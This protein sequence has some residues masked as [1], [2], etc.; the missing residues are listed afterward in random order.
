[1][2]Q[3]VV[4][5]VLPP[6]HGFEPCPPPLVD[7]MLTLPS[8]ATHRYGSSRDDVSNWTAGARDIS[9]FA[10]RLV[11]GTYQNKMPMGPDFRGGKMGLG[12]VKMTRS[13][14]ILNRNQN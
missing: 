14:E 4:V 8:S 9:E 12:R 5:G 3:R 11:G 6:G 1:V 7:Y 10:R 13:G 2:A